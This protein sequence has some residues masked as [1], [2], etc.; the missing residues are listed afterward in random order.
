MCVFACVRAC[1]SAH[2]HVQST[3]AYVWLAFVHV[4]LGLYAIVPTCGSFDKTTNPLDSLLFGGSDRRRSTHR[5]L[6]QGG[7]IERRVTWN[8]NAGISE[9]GLGQQAI[10]SS[11]GD[12]CVNQPPPHPP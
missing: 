12:S 8:Q 2:A 6:L 10:I 5:I 1:A 11:A 3:H 9:S 4:R 7:V